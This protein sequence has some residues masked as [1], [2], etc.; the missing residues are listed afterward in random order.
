VPLNLSLIVPNA[1]QLSDFPEEIGDGVNKKSPKSSNDSQDLAKNQSDIIK[2]S[3]IQKHIFQ[4]ESIKRAE[5]F[6]AKFEKIYG[7][8]QPSK[9]S[10][11]K[12]K[13]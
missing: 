4:N 12:T 13:P 9:A 3:I 7:T 8:G 11:P 2:K 6:R 1:N 10:P 5:R